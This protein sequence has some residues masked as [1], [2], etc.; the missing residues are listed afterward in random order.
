MQSNLMYSTQPLVTVLTARDEDEAAKKAAA[1]K[2]AAEKATAE[3][4]EAERLAKEE[5]DKKKTKPTDEEARLLKESMDR[6]AKLDALAKEKEVADKALEAANARLKD[7]EGLNPAEIRKLVDAAKKAEEDKLKLAGD[8]DAMKKQMNDAHAAELA[9]KDEAHATEKTQLLDANASLHQNIANL[10]VG[11]AFGNSPYVRDELILT[12]AKAR[13]IY[14]PH[15]EHKDGKV[16]AF[17]KPIGVTGRTMFVDGK[18]EPLG[19]EDALKKIV[20][21]DPDRDDVLRSKLK[22]GAGS[23]TKPTPGAK[24]G[25]H[26]ELSGKEKIAAGLKALGKK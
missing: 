15:F 9:K 5:A 26:Q 13:V 4:A 6:K 17:D 12:P 3:K 14:G 22:A 11:G 19:F 7:F 21:A 2:A 1:D 18:G 23:G 16:V 8:W 20:D 10:A 25:E 24:P